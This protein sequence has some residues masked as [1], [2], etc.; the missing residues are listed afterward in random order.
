[1]RRVTAAL[2][3]A[4]LIPAAAS[5]QAPRPPAASRDR[6]LL[7][8]Y[9]VTCHNETRKTA[10][11]MLDRIDPS[12][13][14]VA[15]AEVWELVLRRLQTGSMPPL[16]A[17][18]P[19]D[20]ALDAFTSSLETTLDRDNPALKD[21]TPNRRIDDVD[22]ASRLAMFLWRT[23][24]DEELLAV[25][26]LGQLKSASTL[27]QQVRRMLSDP[28]SR[29]LVA[30]FFN[31]WLYL[32]NLRAVTP[33]PAVFPE[34][35][36]DLRA[37]FAQETQLF[38]ESQLREDRPVTELLS[39]NYTFMNDRLA[40][41]YGIPNV[42]GTEFRRITFSDDR[43]AG[44]LGQGSILAVT[45]YA[46][47]TSPVLRGKYVLDVLLG[48][49]PPDMPPNVP[50][51][52]ED[53]ASRTAPMREQ[54][55]QHRKNPVCA[56]CHATF[57]P[58]GFALENFDA[59]GRWRTTFGGVL[60]DASGTLADGTTFSDPAGLRLALLR[61]HDAFM[62]SLI[63]RL[64][65]YAV[66]RPFKSSDMPVLRKILRDTASHGDVWST[67]FLNIA[68]STPFQTKAS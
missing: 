53:A 15:D 6:A 9:C 67:L 65:T 22:L 16:G 41:H 66:G 3:A 32:S 64:L 55:E 36:E 61:Y 47:R 21:P 10:G 44:L 30:N 29:A 18:R 12:K 46:R 7:D 8:Q 1:M 33:D 40:R 38:L 34:F 50:A 17:P 59:I 14:S 68:Q 42:S 27:E 37:A 62:T 31:P 58:I 26:R 54:M 51:L 56:S 4:L 2:L 28:R 23:G 13:I 48:A 60:I 43:R 11:L 45:S 5:A 49:P 39:A 63:Q 24:P 25:A 57:D 52:K 35:D 20:S 19:D